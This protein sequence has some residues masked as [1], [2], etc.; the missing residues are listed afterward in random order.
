MAIIDSV[1]SFTI[2]AGAVPILLILFA[3][4][5]TVLPENPGI[6]LGSINR[7]FKVVQGLDLQG[8]L[9]VLLE[10]D[11]PPDTEISTEQI[12]T[13][14]DIIE[15]RVNGLGVTEPIIQ[16]AGSN[17]IVVELPGIENPEEAVATIKETGL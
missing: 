12:Q 1:S 11:L 7:E 14:R 9:Q 2:A 4:I 3:A 17:R 15:N 16:V 13:A 10:A 8:G 5:W 6:H